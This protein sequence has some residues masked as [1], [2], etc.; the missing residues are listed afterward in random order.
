MT[1]RSWPRKISAAT[2]SA[3]S[4]TRPRPKFVRYTALVRNLRSSLWQIACTGVL[5][6]MSRRPRLRRAAPLRL[7]AVTVFAK[8]AASAQLTSAKTPAPSTAV[9]SVCGSEPPMPMPTA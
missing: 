7:P 9:N 4:S 2:G 8:E 3:M 6:R 5:T 1:S